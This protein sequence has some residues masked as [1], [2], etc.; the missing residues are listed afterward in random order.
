MTD[1]F[2]SISALI[3]STR[4]KSDFKIDAFK[5]IR[6]QCKFLNPSVIVECKQNITPQWIQENQPCSDHAF[7]RMKPHGFASDNRIHTEVREL[8]SQKDIFK[9]GRL[10]SEKIQVQLLGHGKTHRQSSNMHGQ[11]LCCNHILLPWVILPTSLYHAFCTYYNTCSIV[12]AVSPFVQ[13]YIALLPPHYQSRIVKWKGADHV[14]YSDKIY[15]ANEGPYCHLINP[16]NEAMSTFYQLSLLQHVRTAVIENKPRLTHSENKNILVI[17]RTKGRR[18]YSGHDL[19]LIQLD[20]VS[21]HVIIFE[22]NSTLEDHI[23]LFDTPYCNSMRWYEANGDGE[24][25]FQS[26]SSPRSTLYTLNWQRL[27]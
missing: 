6:S 8:F 4:A 15:I 1:D 24:Y 26:V 9:N 27:I 23:Q 22:G 13:R 11:C 10:M 19:L 12:I 16:H 18:S 17:K 3:N 2:D 7:I 25:V 20:T 5:S 21:K 14:F